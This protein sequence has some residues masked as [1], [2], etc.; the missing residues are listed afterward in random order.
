MQGASFVTAVVHA[1]PL[2]GESPLGDA[3]V[4]QEGDDGGSV[5]FGKLLVV[6]VGANVVGAA[7]DFELQLG[8]ALRIPKTF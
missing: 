4:G 1:V 6:L 5:G 8:P 7:L 3:F 2:G